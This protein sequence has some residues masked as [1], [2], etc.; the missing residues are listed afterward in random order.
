[1]HRVGCQ[2]SIILFLCSRH[3]PQMLRAHICF[4]EILEAQEAMWQGSSSTQGQVSVTTVYQSYSTLGAIKSQW[5][6]TL[7][8]FLISL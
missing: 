2:P 4:P 7:T 8:N 3:V 6:E 5:L 1:M